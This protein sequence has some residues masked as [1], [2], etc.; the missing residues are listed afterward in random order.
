MWTRIIGRSD[1]R[2]GLSQD[3]SHG[4]PPH[5]QH[6]VQTS[7][8]PGVRRR[9][10][11]L[12]AL[13]KRQD[14]SRNLIRIRVAKL[15]AGAFEDDAQAASSTIPADQ[16]DGCRCRR[17]RC[18]SRR[19]RKNDRPAPIRSLRPACPKWI[20]PRL[21]TLVNKPPAGEAWIHEIKWDGYGVP[22]YLADG[23]VTIRTRKCRDWAA[24]IPTIAGSLLKLNV[25]STVIDGEGLRT[26]SIA[27]LREALAFLMRPA[28]AVALSEEYAGAGADLF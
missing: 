17:A 28:G 5:A 2:V 3:E 20:K 16:E 27:D 9:R 22:A 15:E 19:C 1:R 10:N 21:P 8:R 7:D 11:G 25:R 14:L 26:K 6:R 24:L 4:T 18:R 12:H 23:K 13:A